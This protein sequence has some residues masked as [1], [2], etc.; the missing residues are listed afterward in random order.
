[1]SITS[2]ANGKI[3]VTPQQ[4]AGVAGVTNIAAATGTQGFVSLALQEQP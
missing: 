2:D 4:V 3:T 1:L